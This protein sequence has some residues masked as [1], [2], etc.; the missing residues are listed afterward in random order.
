MADLLDTEARNPGPAVLGHDPVLLSG[1]R[2]AV[3]EAVENTGAI[4]F[5]DDPALPWLKN[6]SQ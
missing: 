2:E 4:S 1:P 6:P 3:T 5:R